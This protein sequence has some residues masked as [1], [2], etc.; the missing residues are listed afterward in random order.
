MD[1]VCPRGLEGE[2]GRRRA[3]R[4]AETR[5]RIIE[6]AVE[7]HG[8]VGP[9]LATLTMVAERA[10]LQRHTRYAHF[11]DE[12]ALLWACSGLVEEGDPLPD[13]AAWH[14]LPDPCERLRTRIGALHAWYARNAGLAAYVLRDAEHHAPTRKIAALRLGLPL[15]AMQK[16]PKEG[17]DPAQR[18]MLGLMLGFHA[19]RSQSARGASVRRRRSK[20]RSAPSRRRVAS[21]RVEARLEAAEQRQRLRVEKGQDLREEH[22]RRATAMVDPVVGVGQPRPG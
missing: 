7:L 11:P 6:A 8:T 2:A 3:E 10:G 5:Q 15:R 12:R 19:W 1:P 13:V 4:P 18:A 14:A 21:S 17:F 22:A 9:A 20:P 16:V